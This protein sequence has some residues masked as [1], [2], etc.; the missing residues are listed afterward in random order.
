MTQ[1]QVLTLVSM[2][3]IASPLILW[4]MLP[5]VAILTQKGR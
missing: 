2:L 4:G 3:V 5:V 1:H